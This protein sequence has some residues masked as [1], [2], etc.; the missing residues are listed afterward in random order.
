[1]QKLYLASLVALG[2][3]LP[4]AAHSSGGVYV[5]IGP[6]PPAYYEVVPAPR[7]GWAWVPGYWEWTGH[8]YQWIAGHWVRSRP[9]H[10]YYAPRWYRSAGH[11]Y[12]V[13]GGWR[14]WDVDGD[15]VPNRYDRYPHNPYRR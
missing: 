3:A 14:A 12:Y 2:L 8:R 10:V 1:M 11:W 4:A 7:H 6:P 15:G 9:G 5:N 13:R